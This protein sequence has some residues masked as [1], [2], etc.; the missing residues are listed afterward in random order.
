MRP[1]LHFLQK[2]MVYTSNREEQFKVLKGA[3]CAQ[4]LMSLHTTS[5]R[6]AD[7]NSLCKTFFDYWSKVIIELF[8]DPCART[9]FNF[10]EITA[11]F[12]SQFNMLEHHLAGNV[13]CAKLVNK[14]FSCWLAHDM[15]EFPGQHAV[16]CLY[17]LMSHKLFDPQVF[18]VRSLQI[19]VNYKLAALILDLVN[20][21]HITRTQDFLFEK[22]IMVIG[23]AI[24]FGVSTARFSPQRLNWLLAVIPNRDW[25][26]SS[27]L[28]EFKQQFFAALKVLQETGLAVD[29]PRTAFKSK[30]LIFRSVDAARVL[31]GISYAQ[32]LTGDKR[33]NNI[34]PKR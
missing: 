22:M 24:K 14:L 4:A 16:P 29:I 11:I 7:R 28:P 23:N 1:D 5:M 33:A 31:P 18:Q 8:R 10:F 9:N 25:F 34:S 13:K 2:Q 32:V 26:K 15:E 20:N 30:P 21:S 6:V 17:D 19:K 12:I 3:E 27:D